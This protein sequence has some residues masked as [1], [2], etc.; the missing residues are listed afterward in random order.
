ME[1]VTWE[2]AMRRGRVAMDA[3]IK[4]NLAGIT[5]EEL[6]RADAREAHLE[7]DLVG[8]ELKARREEM[9]EPEPR[10]TMRPRVGEL[11][12]SLRN[13]LNSMETP[14]EKAR[15]FVY[16][17]LR[18]RLDKTDTHV[19]FSFDEVYA[20]WFAKVLQNWSCLV[21]TTLP[22]GMYYLVTFNGD[23]DVIF[24]DAYKKYMNTAIP[25]N[26]DHSPVGTMSP[27]Q[28]AQFR[29]MMYLRH[30][31]PGYPKARPFKDGDI[32]TLHLAEVRQ[33][34]K[35]VLRSKLSSDLLYEVTYNGNQ[36]ETYVD[37]Y[38]K[39]DSIRVPEGED[40]SA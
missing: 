39:W 6:L 21:S 24:V 4:D 38:K 29:V 1:Q 32:T 2:E 34:W 17:Y 10:P 30:E 11:L 20:V 7:R 15:R 40:S 13:T 12:Q 25:R 18:T 8:A 37:V 33:N 14:Q 28:Q 5:R 3:W 35:A 16:E 22:D 9:K 27:E 26:A 36:S 23:I 19:T 31:H